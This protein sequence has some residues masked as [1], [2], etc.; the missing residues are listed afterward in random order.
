MSSYLGI[1]AEIDHQEVAGGSEQGR[2]KMK[3][4][5]YQK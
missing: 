3:I 1:A 5:N 4:I 2:L